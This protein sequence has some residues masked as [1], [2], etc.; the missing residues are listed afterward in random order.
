MVQ[1]LLEFQTPRDNAPHFAWFRRNRRES[2]LCE[3]FML[4]NIPS[5]RGIVGG[6]R[7][8]GSLN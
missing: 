2:G 8:C 5:F 7:L 4:M 3:D 1:V 6:P